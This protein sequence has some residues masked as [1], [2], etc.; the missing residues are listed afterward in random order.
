MAAAV[1][2][3]MAIIYVIGAFAVIIPNLNNILP[4]FLLFFQM[5]LQG[6]LLPGAF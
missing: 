5:R 6:L 3:T 1:V 4:S 2:P